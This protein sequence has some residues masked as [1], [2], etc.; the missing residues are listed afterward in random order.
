M[1]SAG[2]LSLDSNPTFNLVNT[3]SGEHVADRLEKAARPTAGQ[4]VFSVVMTGIMT[5]GKTYVL[6]RVLSY[7]QSV[8]LGSSDVAGRSNL[9][10]DVVSS[11]AQAVAKKAVNAVIIFIGK[12]ETK[13]GKAIFVVSCFLITSVNI[14]AL[15]ILGVKDNAGAVKAGGEALI[16][17]AYNLNLALRPEAHEEMLKRLPEFWV[18]SGE[19]KEMNVVRFAVDTLL[20]EQIETLVEKSPKHTRNKERMQED[21]S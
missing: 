10:T 18:D 5:A 1:G 17:L 21:K 11:T 4:H 15:R 8:A 20:E 9:M 3:G 6:G 13:T 7:V 2:Q 19:G 16:K 14:I 12:E